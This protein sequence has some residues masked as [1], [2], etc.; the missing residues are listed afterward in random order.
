MKTLMNTTFAYDIAFILIT[1]H[2]FP[3]KYLHKHINTLLLWP[4]STMIQVC[5]LGWSVCPTY[6]TTQHEYVRQIAL[7]QPLR[8]SQHTF[9]QT[10]SACVCCYH[11]YTHPV[12]LCHIGH[13][14]NGILHVYRNTTVPCI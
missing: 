7:I 9:E 10:L 4:P 13:I 5:S 12:V 3:Y 2:A 1:F 14:C 6:R 8:R 11:K